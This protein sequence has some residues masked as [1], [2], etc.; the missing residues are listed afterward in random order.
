MIYVRLCS[1]LCRVK[2]VSGE[3]GSRRSSLMR[4]AN[5][6]RCTSCTS[7]PVYATGLS[8]YKLLSI[9]TFFILSNILKSISVKYWDTASICYMIT[10][11]IKLTILIPILYFSKYTSHNWHCW[12]TYL[13]TFYF[14]QIYIMSAVSLVVSLLDTVII[15]D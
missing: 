4:P 10:V 6:E 2:F 15:W 13:H 11:K 14:W 7:A 8:A 1:L 5:I 9:I 3:D 12:A